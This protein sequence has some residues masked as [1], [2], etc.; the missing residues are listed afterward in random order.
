MSKTREAHSTQ[1]DRLLGQP[2]Q[3]ADRGFNEKLMRA[4][5]GRQRA[6]RLSFALTFA[7]W[8]G[9]CLLVLA[10][11]LFPEPVAVS[12]MIEQAAE[13]SGSLVQWLGMLVPL[14]VGEFPP[15]LVLSLFIALASV[16][17]FITQRDLI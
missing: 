17:S 13:L 1:I 6:Y 7:A 8:A 11:L 16:V 12:G 9:L 10:P 3:L 4:V 15:V 5:A 2:A 14:A